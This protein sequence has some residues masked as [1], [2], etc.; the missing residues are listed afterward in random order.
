M[1]VPL[2]PRLPINEYLIRAIFDWSMFRALEQDKHAM[3]HFAFANSVR[4]GF[5]C[6]LR[7]GEITKLLVFDLRLSAVSYES[8]SCV[9]RLRDPKHRSSMG[10]FQFAMVRDAELVIWLAWYGD[11]MEGHL[12][13]WSSSHAKFVRRWK[14]VMCELSI[15]RFKLTFGSLRSGG[16]ARAFLTGIS[17]AQL[18]FMGR[19]KGQ[20]SLEVYVQE[21]MAHLCH[22]SL[23]PSSLIT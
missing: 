17:I 12:P 13:L 22:C 2:N 11:G 1:Q 10:R 18:Q 16:A 23:S 19:W 9:V 14:V 4:L 20:S 5:E 6:L 15:Q 8:I 3:E 21:A 7:P